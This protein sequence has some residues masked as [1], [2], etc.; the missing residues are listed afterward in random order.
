MTPP[1]IGSVGLGGGATSL[2]YYKSVATSGET[3][4]IPWSLK[5]DHENGANLYRTPG[6]VGNRKTWTLSM[7][8]KH[9]AIKNTGTNS[10]DTY[11]FDAGNSNDDQ[12]AR[13]TIEDDGQI[14]FSDY[15]TVYLR[16]NVK[17]RDPSA[18]MHIVFSMDTTQASSGDRMKLWVNGIPHHNNLL[19]DS[20]PSQDHNFPFNAVEEHGIG[21]NHNGAGGSSSANHNNFMMAEV[22]WIDGEVKSWTDFAYVSDTDF[23]YY[24]KEPS[25]LTYGTNGFY[26]DF[27]D[28]TSTTTLGYDASSNSNN[29]TT[30]A[31]QLTGIDQSRTGDVPVPHYTDD[32]GFSSI[33]GNF[34]TMQPLIR[35]DTDDFFAITRGNQS[36]R[37]VENSGQGT[38]MSTIGIHT[39]KAFFEY[40][41]PSTDETYVYAGLCT[42]N[43]IEY[44]T[45][46][47][48]TAYSWSIRQ[49]GA[50]CHAGSEANPATV[51]SSNTIGTTIGVYIDATNGEIF[52]DQDGVA[53]YSGN[54]VWTGINT[55]GEKDT[56]IH[57]AMGHNKHSTTNYNFG[58]RAWA[59]GPRVAMGGTEEYPPLSTLHP[60]FTT[61]SDSGQSVGIG[62]TMVNW[63]G[64]GTGSGSG[65]NDD[66]SLNVGFEPD[67]I[68][69]KNRDNVEQWYM[70]DSC[71][72]WA[73]DKAI[74]F[75]SGGEQSGGGCER[76]PL[77]TSGTDGFVI[78]TGEPSST[79][80]EVNFYNRQY[81][82]W[83]WKGGGQ[84]NT[85]N[86]DGTGYA[87]AAAAGL[88]GGDITPKA[89]SVNTKT[90]F[91]VILIDQ[92]TTAGQNVPTGL[93][94]SGNGLTEC[95]W[96]Y[97]L[98]DGKMEFW[99]K[100][101][102]WNYVIQMS[103]NDAASSE[104]AGGGSTWDANPTNSRTR[105]MVRVGNGNI[106]GDAVD[107]TIFYCWTHI[108][109]YSK[110]DEW[111]GNND[112][113][114]PFVYTGFK[115]AFLLYK[116]WDNTGYWNMRDSMRVEYDT[117]K[118]WGSPYNRELYPAESDVES[119]HASRDIDFL[120]DG[121]KI[122]SSSAAINGDGI[123]FTY[124]C[125]AEMP[126]E[127][128]NAGTSG[129]ASKAGVPLRTVPSE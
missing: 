21:I 77:V 46:C 88:T 15:S 84:S 76:Y 57:A 61:Y 114:G 99:H 91:S 25:G 103:D 5:L 87:T 66:L 86:K 27:A 80:G 17:F 124:M 16:T 82:A 1:L 127:F 30:N 6:G 53:Q 128:G 12:W 52:I 117:T 69:I 81:T 67:F 71:R 31:L 111:I 41:T 113:N 37:G 101:M 63:I 34:A 4:N 10:G 11:L 33:R 29:W 13:F 3:K 112:V 79:G 118:Y 14:K 18:W 90:G 78:K 120:A 72:G 116:A 58:N 51:C 7:W 96:A 115:P 32:V 56:S 24:P 122:R 73:K 43:H 9:Y 126:M 95:V 105:G 47:G 36:I 104:S 93:E 97:N 42:P 109:G 19:T 106:N 75:A 125:F 2:A 92:N 129:G 26:L 28:A 62:S 60:S 59:Y 64:T 44:D 65:S 98:H 119:H 45:W 50:G 48:G 38:I 108:P 49:D 100:K 123:Y 70:W 94:D 121:F 35:G 39:G 102:N 54:A 110:F 107:D 22:H 40:H 8:V 89:S 83:C 68:L 85:F 20:P 23:G 55:V 74:R